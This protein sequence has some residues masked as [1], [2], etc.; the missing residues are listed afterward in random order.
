[1]H[2]EPNGVPEDGFLYAAVMMVLGAF[3]L[4]RAH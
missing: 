3:L 1:M 4:R 2:P